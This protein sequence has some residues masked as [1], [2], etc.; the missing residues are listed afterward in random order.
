[1]LPMDHSVQSPKDNTVI[2][3][4]NHQTF[5]PEAVEA[6]TTRQAG[7]PWNGKYRCEGL[8]IIALTLLAAAGITSIFLGG[9]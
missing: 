9:H 2:R 5:R 1:M 3:H 8:I 6:Y 7:D 4:Y